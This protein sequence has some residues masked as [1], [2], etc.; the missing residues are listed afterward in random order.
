MNFIKRLIKTIQGGAGMGLITA[1][2]PPVQINAENTC[3]VIIGP[4]IMYRFV[5]PELRKKY[6]R[7]ANS[8]VF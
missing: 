8:Y 4:P 7:H 6:S 1:I 3:A 5:L 2:I